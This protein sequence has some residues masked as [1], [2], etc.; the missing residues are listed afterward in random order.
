MPRQSL[1]GLSRSNKKE[2]L[3]KMAPFMTTNIN[4]KNGVNWSRIF[5]FL[6]GSVLVAAVTSFVN[7]AVMAEKIDSI[8]S[9]VTEIKSCVQAQD[10]RIRM[11][12]IKVAVHEARSGHETR[13]KLHP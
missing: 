1:P 2:N 13:Q 10:E 11:I 8:K 4:G 6:V 3:L 9:S 5:E 7:M 12:E